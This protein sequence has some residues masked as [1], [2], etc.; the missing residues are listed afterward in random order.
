M[1]LYSAIATRIRAF[2][3]SRKPLLSIMRITPNAAR[4]KARA[5]FDERIVVERTMA[6]YAELCTIP[7]ASAEPSV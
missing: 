7:Q 1:F 2:K 6:V 3:D 5:Q 4:R